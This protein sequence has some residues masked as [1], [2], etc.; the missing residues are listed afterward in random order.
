MVKRNRLNLMVLRLKALPPRL[1]RA[2]IT[3]AFGHRVRFAAAAG[4]QFDE[5]SEARAVAF[6]S[7]RRKVQNHIGTVHAAAM[8]LLA[9]SVT[10]AVFG[11]NV[12]DSHVPLLKSMQ[13]DYT[14]RAQ[15]GLRAVAT[16][17]QATRD[18][19]RS[20]K[21]GDVEVPVTVTDATGAEP[22]QAHMVWA[23]IPKKPEDH[24]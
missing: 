24:E 3:R 17:S 11:M 23:W 12:P 13:L 6:L 16:L 4:V 14:H 21:R 22:L 10:G 9:E 18:H 7:D 5:L 19:I 1:R 8:A 20:E 2:I 15:G